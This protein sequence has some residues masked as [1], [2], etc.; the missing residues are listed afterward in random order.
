MITERNLRVM[1]SGVGGHAGAGAVIALRRSGLCLEIHGM[2]FEPSSA[3]A[4]L[5]DFLHLSPLVSETGYVEFL[6]DL[7]LELEIDVFIPTIDS[8][9]PVIA[10]NKEYLRARA[11]VEVLVGNVDI[12]NACSDK[13]LT[14]MLLQRAG[15]RAL[16]TY[17][18]DLLANNSFPRELEDSRN[19]R[20]ILKPRSG[21]GSEGLCIVDSWRDLPNVD[22]PRAYVVQ[23]FIPEE[24]R[25]F[26]AGLYVSDRGE[27]CV[28]AF[29]RTLVRGSTSSAQTIDGTVGRQLHESLGRLSEILGPGYWNVQGK[30]LAGEAVV[31]EINPRFSGTLEIVTNYFNAP[32]MWISDRFGIPFEGERRDSA[33]VSEFYVRGYFFSRGFSLDPSR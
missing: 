13:Y 25:E 10:Q 22:N 32:A 31:F 29:W 5:C 11:G 30:W 8:E 21:R 28:A 24:F 18:Y 3:G 7:F 6:S 12:V 15:F 19:L 33:E 16:L 27:S 2:N 20:W 1:V 23:E 26:T 17:R 9:I 14:Q 4:Y